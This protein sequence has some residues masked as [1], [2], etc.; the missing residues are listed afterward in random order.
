MIE[1]QMAEH[2]HVDLCVVKAGVPKRREQ[3]V[4]F[5]EDPIAFP[6]FRLK[7]CADAGFEQHQLAVQIFDQQ[8]P[9]GEIN[10]VVLVGGHPL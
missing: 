1:M 2:H 4:L 5:L 7:E 9:A 3:H 8:S 6:E 10:P